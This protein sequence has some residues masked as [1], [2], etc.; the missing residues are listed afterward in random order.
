MDNFEQSRLLERIEMLEQRLAIL[1]SDAE[2]MPAY[3]NPGRY[4]RVTSGGKSSDGF[5]PEYTCTVCNGKQYVPPI[6]EYE[7]V[8]DVNVLVMRLCPLCRG[9]GKMRDRLSID[10]LEELANS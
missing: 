7:S 10:E 1:E 3:A 2:K 5:G 4:Y 8:Y 9:S 6:G